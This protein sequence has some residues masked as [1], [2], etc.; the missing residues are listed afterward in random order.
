MSVQLKYHLKQLLIFSVIDVA[1]NYL[2]L[3]VF[4]DSV[5]SASG[6]AFFIM[7][8]PLL[9]AAVMCRITDGLTR[10]RTAFLCSVLTIVNGATA[11][12]I[13]LFDPFARAITSENYVE[14]LLR[15][16]AVHILIFMPICICIGLIFR[17][18]KTGSAEFDKK[19]VLDSDLMD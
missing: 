1:A 12:V 5:G 8:T 7:G 3:Y 4:R 10:L 6:L 11:I 2:V 19:D 9:L 18:R 17:K 13:N 15:E 16:V 14:E